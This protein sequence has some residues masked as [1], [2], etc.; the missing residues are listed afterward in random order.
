MDIISIIRR[1]REKKELTLDEIKYFVSKLVRD[2]ITEA[3]AAALLSYIYINGLTAEEILNL[4]NAM[5]S[6]G[7][8]ID[9]SEISE[10][11]VDKHSTGGVGD[12]V[13]LLLM[14]ILASLGIPVAKILNRGYGITGGII[15][16]L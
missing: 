10:N 5:A 6:S 9:L 8:M 7:D 4:S 11:I 1:K 3:Q 12:K 13:T 14:P 2:E 15:D 16:K